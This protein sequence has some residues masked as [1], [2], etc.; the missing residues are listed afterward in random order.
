MLKRQMSHGQDQF[1]VLRLT[2]NQFPR[3]VLTFAILMFSS[4]KELI[5]E[6]PNFVIILADNPGY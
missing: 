6:R 1:M 2:T 3:L 5:A 4:A